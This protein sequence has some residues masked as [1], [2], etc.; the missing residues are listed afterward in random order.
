MTDY[1][2][3]KTGANNLV[4]FTS[5]ISSGNVRLLAQATAGNTIK[6]RV[7]RTLNTI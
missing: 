2:V 4:T 1:G 7:V 6:V 3:V 5:D